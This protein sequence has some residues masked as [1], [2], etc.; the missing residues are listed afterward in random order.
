MWAIIHRSICMRSHWQ[1]QIKENA[2]VFGGKKV[3]LSKDCTYNNG[4]IVKF[5]IDVACMILGN[6]LEFRFGVLKTKFTDTTGYYAQIEKTWADGTVHGT[7]SDS[8]E[9]CSACS[10]GDVFT[11]LMKFA[12]SAKAHLYG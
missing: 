9:S 4:E 11:E 7:A 5:D 6:A 12:D 10:T 8:I 2:P 1:V 3:Y